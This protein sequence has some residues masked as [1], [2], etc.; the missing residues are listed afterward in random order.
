MKSHI[1]RLLYKL[2]FLHMIYATLGIYME[3][4]SL[5]GYTHQV[6]YFFKNNENNLKKTCSI[7][8]HFSTGK[9]T[10]SLIFSGSN[11]EK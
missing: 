2:V 7:N 11:P 6:E 8:H 4:T 3:T 9:N 1:T 5:I 10:C